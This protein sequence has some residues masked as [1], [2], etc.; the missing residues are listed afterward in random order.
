M[1]YRATERQGAAHRARGR[2][3][4]DA[5][6]RRDYGGPAMTLT[7]AEQGAAQ[8]HEFRGFI[9]FPERPECWCGWIGDPYHSANSARNAHARHQAKATGSDAMQRSYTPRLHP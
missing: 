9:G 7:E 6:V 1:L 2:S 8:R 5:L 3:L 4:G